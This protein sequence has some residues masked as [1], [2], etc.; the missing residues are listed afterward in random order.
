M[1]SNETNQP[2]VGDVI[3]SR[4]RDKLKTLHHYYQ[5]PYDHKTWQDGT[6]PWKALPNKVTWH[7]DYVVLKDHVQN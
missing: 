6:L 3:H 4:S 7:F 2:D 1:G 5:S